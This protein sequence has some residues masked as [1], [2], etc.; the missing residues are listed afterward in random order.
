[1]SGEEQSRFQRSQADGHSDNPWTEIFL[2]LKLGQGPSRM[3]GVVPC[4][5]VY[6]DVNDDVL[7]MLEWSPGGDLFEL[8][9]SWRPN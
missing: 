8:A 3:R 9:S 4:W 1:M 2:A 7:L 6:S 5:G